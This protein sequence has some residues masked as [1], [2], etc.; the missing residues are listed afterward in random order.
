ML[1]RKSWSGCDCHLQ[2]KLT[3][4]HHCTK[5]RVFEYYPLSVCE[6]ILV[7]TMFISSY[8]IRIR[9]V[10][11]CSPLVTTS[12]LQPCCYY[13]LLRQDTTNN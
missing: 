9:C 8:F 12:V 1:H 11:A 6:C 13:F 3:H 7:V 5:D 10:P 2:H 4:I